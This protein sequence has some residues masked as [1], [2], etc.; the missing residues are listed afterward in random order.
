M[1][2]SRDYPT[3]STNTFQATPCRSSRPQR[4]VLIHLSTPSNE[5][6]TGLKGAFRVHKLLYT[7]WPGLF[8]ACFLKGSKEHLEALHNPDY[9]KWPWLFYFRNNLLFYPNYESS[10]CHHDNKHEKTQ[11][12]IQ[13][14]LASRDA[15]T[16]GRLAMEKKMYSLAQNWIMLHNILFPFLPLEYKN[17]TV[18][19][20][21]FNFIEMYDM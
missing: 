1:S 15:Q 16:F 20:T 4:V 19:I 9:N 2:L 3:V 5:E 12:K 8:P 6:A 10:T 18:A 7:L 11:I 14:P 17:K 21:I 13:K